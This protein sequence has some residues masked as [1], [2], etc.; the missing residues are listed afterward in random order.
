MIFPEKRGIS[1][2]SF[3]SYC[4]TGTLCLGMYE[5]TAN[6]F[7]GLLSFSGENE[8]E[9]SLFWAAAAC[10]RRILA[11]Y[12]H[13]KTASR[14]WDVWDFWLS[15]GSNC[16]VGKRSFGTKNPLLINFLLAT[17]AMIKH[18]FEFRSL[19]QFSSLENTMI[20]EK[21]LML[22]LSLT[23]DSMLTI[24]INSCF[25]RGTEIKGRKGGLTL[26]KMNLHHFD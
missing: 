16:Y 21:F 2:R 19:S 10:W 12:W 24:L 20:G 14:V 3:T 7:G 13:E 9:D 8:N 17:A 6:V 18:N 25:T 4:S 26:A 1:R 11:V 15:F 5:K 22:L 23:P